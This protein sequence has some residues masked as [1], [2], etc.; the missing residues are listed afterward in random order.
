MVT[1]GHYGL[2][3]LLD[4]DAGCSLEEFVIFYKGTSR[5]MAERNRMLVGSFTVA[6]GSI[7]DKKVFKEFN[8]TIDRI[9]S[10]L[11]PQA[12]ERKA[13]TRGNREQ[14]IHTVRELEKLRPLMG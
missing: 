1:E 12:T 7:F 2:H 8:T 9:V 11:S 13:K 5:L 4:Y 3:D 10:K 6:I 14:M